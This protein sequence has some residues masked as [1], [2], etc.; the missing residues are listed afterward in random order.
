MTWGDLRRASLRVTWTT[1]FCG[2]F[3]RGEMVGMAGYIRFAEQKLRH[4]G[5]LWGVFVQPVHRGLGIGGALV[6]ELLRLAT[7]EH[8]LEQIILTVRSAAAGG[9]AS[10][11]A[12]WIRDLRA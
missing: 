6:R 9:K 12:Y 1:L 8:G 2:A 11:R 4:K 7:C 10:L 3:L 5:R